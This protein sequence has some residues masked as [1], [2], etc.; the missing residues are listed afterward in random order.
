MFKK[1]CRWGAIVLPLGLII[2]L[3][4]TTWELFVANSESATPTWNLFDPFNNALFSTTLWADV[5]SSV[6]MTLF[7]IVAVLG[8]VV[9]LAMSVMFLLDNLNKTKLQKYERIA[10]FVLLGLTV[11]G[12]AFSALAT[13]VNVV[14]V[15]NEVVQAI[16]GAT[17]VYV[18]TIFGLLASIAGIIGSCSKNTKKFE[19]KTK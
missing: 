10:S 15:D 8:L 6:W 7:M 19:S 5:F 12:I 16:N 4:A 13:I 11:F 14:S 17:G 2:P 3:F 18:F 9:G 1:I